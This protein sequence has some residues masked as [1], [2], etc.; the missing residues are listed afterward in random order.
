MYRRSA[1]VIFFEKSRPFR[2]YLVKKTLPSV[3]AALVFGLVFI[4]AP[5]LSIGNTDSSGSAAS[6]PC[7]IYVS[8]CDATQPEHGK[9][10]PGSIASGAGLDCIEVGR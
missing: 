6:V 5:L 9:P 1:I 4:V 7:H 8:T 3:A 10:D 2:S